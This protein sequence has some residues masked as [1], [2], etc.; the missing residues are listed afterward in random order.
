MAEQVKR[1]LL[2]EQVASRLR[3][4]IVTGRL[5][6]GHRLR[7]DAL[8]RRFGVS[9]LPIRD[10]LK[11]LHAEGLIAVSREGATV[12]HLP[13][14]DLE[15]VYEMR[16]LLEPLNAQIAVPRLTINDIE[17]M[18]RCLRPDGSERRAEPGV[19]PAARPVPHGPRRGLRTTTA[20][21]RDDRDPAPRVGALHTGLPGRQPARRSPGG[22]TR[23]HPRGDASTL[24]H[25][26]GGASQGPP[27][28]HQG[29]AHALRGPGSLPRRGTPTHGNHGLSGAPQRS[30]DEAV[31]KIF[32]RRFRALDLGHELSD[33]IP[34]Y[35]GRMKVATWWH[36]T[37]EE[38][39]MRMGDTDFWGY[40][41]K[42]MSLCEHVSTH[43]GAVFHFNPNRPDLSV[44]A[45][46]LST[47]ITPAAWLD[48]SL[49]RLQ[50]ALD[51]ADVTLEA[52]MTLLHF[53]GAERFWGEDPKKLVTQYPGMSE[54][55]SRWLL[56]QGIVNLCNDAFS[57]DNPTNARYPNH[58]AFARRRQR[59]LTIGSRRAGPARRLLFV[60][61]GRRESHARARFRM[62]E[63]LD[64]RERGRS[65][66]RAH[67]VEPPDARG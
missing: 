28:F 14:K 57:I 46:S 8:A 16:F 59:H 67:A 48:L 2:H 36:L 31:L 56:D 29:L 38:S 61:G 43:V 32:G 10:A 15:D 35:P 4:E 52:G 60:E 63:A 13:L 30:Q 3:E 62:G 54:E 18:E 20:P 65:D 6:A 47:M 24:R 17:E 39:L 51:E 33:E 1:S 53:T 5:P 7:Q 26:R 55:A 22:S 64:P 41:L 11:A 66:L 25:G 50:V 27:R 34:V 45:I 37:H 21:G 58:Q 23:A 19:V 9:R 49:G 42:G 44:D 40:G 12:G